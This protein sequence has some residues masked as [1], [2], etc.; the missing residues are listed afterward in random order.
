MR[1]NKY[2]TLPG[3][4]GTN[5]YLYIEPEYFSKGDIISVKAKKLLVKNKPRRKWYHLILQFITFGIFKANYYY[6]VRVLDDNEVDYIE[7]VKKRDRN[8]W[9]SDLKTINNE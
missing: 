3:I 4:K 1:L 2:D 6:I 8:L 5:C 7:Y 9:F